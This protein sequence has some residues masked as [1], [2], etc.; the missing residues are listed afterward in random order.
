MKG[1]DINLQ[2]I[3]QILGQI[4]RAFDVKSLVGWKSLSYYDL[5]RKQVIYVITFKSLC[6]IFISL[7]LAVYKFSNFEKK[8]VYK[9]WPDIW[10]HLNWGNC[11]DY[12]NYLKS[13]IFSPG[14]LRKY[15][16]NLLFSLLWPG[17]IG[18]RGL[19]GGWGETSIRDTVRGGGALGW[20]SL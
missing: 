8:T 6:Y 1:W 14:F 2:Q 13:T 7:Y 3:L 16:K 10:V 19:S 20:C 5:T 9:F 4:L 11:K 15:V 17:G 18:G 12:D